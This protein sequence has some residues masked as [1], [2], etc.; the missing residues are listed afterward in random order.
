MSTRCILFIL[1][2]LF[3]FNLASAEDEIKKEST[4]PKEVLKENKVETSHHVT[5][6]GVDIPYKSTVGNLLIKDEKGAAKATIF[7]ISYVKEGVDDPSKRPVTFCFNGGP[8]SSSIWL[9]MG[10]LGPRRVRLDDEGYSS[11]PYESVSNEFSAL[12]LTDLVFIDPISTGFS[13]VAQGEDPK[14]F[15]GVDEDIKSIGNFIRLYTTKEN[16][17]T[18]PKFLAGES[19]GTTRA[20]GLAQ[21]LHDDHSFYVNGIILVSSV[22][23]FQTLDDEQGGNDLPYIL[24]LPSLTAT[25]WYHKKL[26]DEL[27]GDLPKTLAE[28][29]S[30]AISD[31]TLALMKGDALT[32]QERKSL[33]EKLAYYTAL[34]P[35]YIERSNLR[36][37]P[38]RF[39]KE[40]LRNERRTVGRFD[41]RFKGIDSNSVGEYIQYDPSADVVAGAYTAVF[42]QYLRTDLKWPEDDEYQVISDVQPWNYG[43][44]INQYLHVGETLREIMTRNPH[45]Q[46]F[47]ASGY[48]DLATPYFGTDYTFDHLALDPSLRDHVWMTYYEAG[49]MM[50][51]HRPSLIDFKQNLAKWM[52][53]RFGFGK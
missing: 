44:A 18:S 15:H 47:V 39:S 32:S 19:Y 24:F 9:H 27:Q 38:L 40:L 36:I 7:Y 53:D 37:S 28:V 13:R 46:V 2:A 48:Y 5:I 6:N 33:T 34:S 20:A 49:H 26:S 41:G 4:L 30:F 10:V 35:D 17:W 23:N 22:L 1:C 51:I 14:Q 21:H 45:L 31:Y 43:K 50:Y 3:L 12:D 42:N 29:E 52:R 11:P 16:R 8:G 25:A